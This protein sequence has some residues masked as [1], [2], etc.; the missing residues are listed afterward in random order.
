[1]LGEVKGVFG[2]IDVVPLI[3]DLLRP[4]IIDA[5]ALGLRTPTAIRVPSQLASFRTTAPFF[6]E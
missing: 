1:M 2:P 4:V 6:L 5:I 3:S